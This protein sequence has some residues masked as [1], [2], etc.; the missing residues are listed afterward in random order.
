MLNNYSQVV[1]KMPDALICS[2]EKLSAD[3][4]TDIATA[5]IESSFIYLAFKTDGNNANINHKLM[6]TAKFLREREDKISILKDQSQPHGIKFEDQL[7]SF[8]IMKP[9]GPEDK[10]L[11]Q[12]TIDAYKCFYV[13]P[14]DEQQP[15]YDHYVFVLIPIVKFLE[16]YAVLV[17]QCE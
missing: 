11:F 6:N 3:Y 10:H 9:I 13:R 14:P 12:E 4:I 17:R 7:H 15:G 2:V 8:G 5:T 1:R 16:K